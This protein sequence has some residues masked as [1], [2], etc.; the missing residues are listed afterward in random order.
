MDLRVHCDRQSLCPSAKRW[1][2]AETE[3]LER[4]D[5][6][7][8]SSVSRPLDCNNNFRP[9]TLRAFI[10]RSGSSLESCNR[11]GTS[12][13]PVLSMTILFS[14]HHLRPG[15][16]TFAMQG[17]RYKTAEYMKTHENEHS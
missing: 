15:S 5:I 9:S 7:R 2:Q 17:A 13:I 12:T 10:S 1:S 8:L 3:V 11:C 4:T 16:A 6:C 14:Y